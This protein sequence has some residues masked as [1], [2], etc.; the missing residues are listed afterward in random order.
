ML[1]VWHILLNIAGVL[2]SEII[3][4]DEKLWNCWIHCYNSTFDWLYLQFSV[5]SVYICIRFIAN[6]SKE[7]L[8]SVLVSYEWFL[9]LKKTVQICHTSTNHMI[10]RIERSLN[11]FHYVLLLCNIDPI[12]HRFPLCHV[13]FSIQ[14][15]AYMST[16]NTY[17]PCNQ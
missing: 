7:I 6:K 17:Y 2:T 1:V 13:C 9:V 3:T 14:F 11:V 5:K 4:T 10:K 15:S 8:S 16:C 12:T